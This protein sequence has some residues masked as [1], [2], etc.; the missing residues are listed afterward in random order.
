M[1]DELTKDERAIVRALIDGR[2]MLMRES[3]KKITV[4]AVIWRL[5]QE[6]VIVDMLLPADR[7]MTGSG[8]PSIV[9]SQ[10]EIEELEL[11][12]KKLGDFPK[13]S[14]LS[15]SPEAVSRYLVV[16]QWLRYLGGHNIP[17]ATATFLLLARGYSASSVAKLMHYTTRR[18]VSNVRYYSL[19]CMA[20]AL[21]KYLPENFC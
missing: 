7:R 15:A 19:R 9:R 13:G 8:L 10:A 20:A 11:E 4:E 16:M 14:K 2:S 12:W 18:A 21:T 1:D 17:R 3:V 6:A 5:F